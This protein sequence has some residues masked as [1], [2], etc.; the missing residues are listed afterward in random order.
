M[1]KIGKIS[2]IPK[3]YSNAF[4]T[5]E[6]SLRE[7]GMSRMPGTIQIRFPYK[8]LNGKYRTGLDENGKDILVI[9][10]ETLRKAEQSRIKEL[11][12]SLEAKTGL[13]LSPT[14]S[15]YNHVSKGP[16]IKVDPYRLMDGDNIFNLDDPMQAITYNWLRVHP[17]IASSYQAYERGEFPP[18]TM[19]YV[20]DEDVE[21]E[22]T[23][24][25]KKNANDA[26]IKFDSWSLEKRRKVARLLDLPVS[27]DTREE[28]VYNL[29]DNLLKEGTIKAGM[30]K[31]SDSL[32]VF[33]SYA[34]LKDDDL[35]VRDLVEQLL[36]HHVY[37]EKKGGKIY[38]G[39]QEMFANKEELV[40]F[41]MDDR[42]QEDLFELQN[43][44]KMKKMVNV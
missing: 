2:V 35:L 3:D 41:L 19:Y 4:P 18:D 30:H 36:R 44:L 6:K 34:N 20:N 22:I 39:E 15:F 24:R 38:E 28:V 31:G 42:N 9:P 40:E 27:D 11:R 13:D 17:A 37:R 25:K 8:E 12:K 1:G 32:K 14:S 33:T 26:I 43:K 5:M 16:G 10:D 7:K 29:V 23:Y 21:S